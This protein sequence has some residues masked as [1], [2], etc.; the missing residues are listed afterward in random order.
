MLGPFFPDCLEFS[1]FFRDLDPAEEL[2][3]LAMEC[4][5]LG[6]REVGESANPGATA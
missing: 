2:S 4:E 1:R 5:M 3:Y 6:Q